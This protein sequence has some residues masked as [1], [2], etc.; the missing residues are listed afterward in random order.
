MIL[1]DLF[2]NK[3]FELRRNHK[4]N[5]KKSFLEELKKYEGQSD[6][7]VS[8][9]ADVGIESH[10]KPDS[11][12]TAN[13]SGHKIGVNP[14]STY[15]ETPIGIY[16]YPIDYVLELHG[17]VPFAG[18][19]PFIH[20]LSLAVPTDNIL[21]LDSYTNNHLDQDIE[22][23]V[24]YMEDFKKENPQFIPPKLKAYKDQ[25]YYNKTKQITRFNDPRATIDY[26]IREAIVKSPGGYIWNIT[27]VLANTI[28]LHT[29]IDE[30]AVSTWNKIFRILGYQGAVDNGAGIIHHNEPTQAV[31]FSIKAFKVV[32]TIRNIKPENP[33]TISQICIE[34]PKLFLKYLYAGKLDFFQIKF[35]MQTIPRYA[36]RLLEWDK[37]PDYVKHAFN[38]KY[39]YWIS[40]V[41]NLLNIIPL[42]EDQILDLIKE[43]YLMIFHLISFTNKYFTPKILDYLTKN[44]YNIKGFLDDHSQFYNYVIRIPFT[45]EQKQ[46]I[47][48]KADEE[49]LSKFIKARGG[50]LDYNWERALENRMKNQD[51]KM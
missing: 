47:I 48:N 6:I 37:L 45:Y 4:V 29:D 10:M 27:R 8:F 44:F 21:M 18:N 12:L 13:V 43:N 24:E 25:D 51:I 32:E 30:N 49:T 39:K 17:K 26:A 14:K 15:Y 36:L 41:P 20:I 16:T 22:S 9:T 2:E 38:L 23:L 33:R 34:N 1:Q 40:E 19:Q 42:N 50:P 11:L 3:L 35:I 5:F 7:F 28:K 46:E 31:F